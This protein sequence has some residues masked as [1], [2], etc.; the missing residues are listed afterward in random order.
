MEKVRFDLTMPMVQRRELASLASET[1]LS[2]A[3]L[4]RFG[5]RYVLEHRELF[6]RP[7]NGNQGGLDDE[8]RNPGAS[9]A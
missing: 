3:D 4:A 2:S 8:W 9:G 7:I 6:L 1:G 5:I